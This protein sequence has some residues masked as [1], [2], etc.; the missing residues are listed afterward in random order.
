MTTDSYMTLA[1]WLKER[2]KFLHLTQK[3]VAA[4][5]PCSEQLIKK[6]ELDTRKLQPEMAPRMAEVLDLHGEPCHRFLRIVRGEIGFERLPA[7]DVGHNEVQIVKPTQPAPFQA[8]PDLPCW[9]GRKQE[10]QRLRRGLEKRQLI[11]IYGIRGMGGVGKTSLAIHAAYILRGLFR[12]GVLWARLDTSD[13]MSILNA[14]AQAYGNDVKHLTDVETRSAAV[15]DIL[16]DKQVLIILDN[17]E[18]SE[19]IEPL[20]PP[21][22][23]KCAVLVTSRD[24]L[25][26][27]DSWE[28]IHL[29]AFNVDSHESRQLFT[30][31]LGQAYVDQ[32]CEAL[33]QIA[34]LLGHLPLALMI[35]AGRLGSVTHPITPSAL[36]LELR[37]LDTRLDPLIRENRSVRASFN[38]SYAALSEE[39]QV[40]FD[41]L[42]VFGG[43]DFDIMAAAAVTL[44]NEDIA[45]SNLLRLQKLSLVNHSQGERFQLHPLL[46]EYGREHLKEMKLG[47]RT[48]GYDMPDPYESMVKHYT[49]RAGATIYRRN[50]LIPEISNLIAA[51]QTTDERK[52]AALLPVALDA[53]F[54]ILRDHGLLE[55]AERYAKLGLAVAC[56]VQDI[57]GQALV[58]IVQSEIAYWHNQS[59]LPILQQALPLAR[60]CKDMRLVSQCLRHIGR[61]YLREGGKVIQAKAY[62]LE[63]YDIAQQ[64][65]LE[66]LFPMFYS[67]LGL[68]AFYEGDMALAHEYNL[69]AY[70]IATKHQMFND[71]YP[72]TIQNLVS[73]LIFQKRFDEANRYLDQG[74]KFCLEYQFNERLLLLYA[75]GNEL[76]SEQSNYEVAKTYALDGLTLAQRLSNVPHIGTF[77]IQLGNIARLQKDYMRARHYLDEAMTLVETHGRVE[78]KVAIYLRTAFLEADLGNK[79]EARQLAIKA[80]NVFETLPPAEMKEITDFLETIDDD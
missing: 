77:M 15:R 44:V 50:Q 38:I 71:L 47:Q 21:S 68:I 67:A 18:N 51:L 31:V 22:S 25:S 52:L 19:Q 32:C 29:Q 76:A 20:L 45:K 14:F 6:I 66:D 74:I 63:G 80:M 70:E 78:H 10:L 49:Q 46:R 8:P 75:N 57:R 73:D 65:Q 53:F 27:L 37:Q 9:V 56:A 17:A 64:Y 35:I 60:Q 12:D 36:L 79:L 61:W 39:L 23:A 4:A 43:D 30:K 16:K 48:Q 72:L 62:C 41:R 40:F 5:I 42:G 26:L 69:K 3:Q 34:D 11:S 33:D 24:E 54:A 55:M 1:I 13:T 28:R 59:Q 7:V 58:L 2:R